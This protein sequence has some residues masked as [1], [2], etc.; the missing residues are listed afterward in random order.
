L[1]VLSLPVDPVYYEQE[2]P[3]VLALVPDTVHSVLELGCA[4]GRMATELKARQ[5]CRVAGVEYLPEAAAIAESRLDR[6]IVGDC[7]HLDFAELFESAEFDCLIAADVLEH[8]RDPELVL[9]RLMPHLTD[10]ACVVV[11]IPNVRNAGVLESAVEGNWTYQQWGILDRTHLRFFT[12]REI[13]RMFARLGFV[14]EELTSVDSPQLQEWEELDRPTSVSFGDMTLTGLDQAAIREF[15]VVQWVARARRTTLGAVASADEPVTLNGA[16]PGF[17]VAESLIS[18]L[19][20]E[21]AQ[22]RAFAEHVHAGLEAAERIIAERAREVDRL[23]SQI[24]AHARAN[25]LLRGQLAQRAE[26]EQALR[27]QLAH[28]ITEIDDLRVAHGQ[29]IATRDAAYQSLNAMRTSTSW[30]ITAPLRAAAARRLTLRG[31]VD[32]ATR[33]RPRLRAI[34]RTAARMLTRSG[35]NERLATPAL[36]DHHV[37][38]ALPTVATPARYTLVPIRN[39]AEYHGS[40]AKPERRLI[41]F[42]HIL[43]FP[44]RAGNEYR[45][46]RM[47]GWLESQGWSVLLLACPMYAELPSDEQIEQAAA[48]FAN[49]V[50]CDRD[51]TLRYRLQDNGTMLEGLRGCRPRA[52]APLLGESEDG[53]P[54]EQNLLQVLRQFCPDVLAEVLLHLDAQFEPAVILAEYIFMTRPLPLVRQGVIKA[55]DTIDVFSSKSTKVERFGIA[56]RLSLSPAAETKLLERADLVI[57]IQSAESKEFQA[58]VPQRKVITVGVDFPLSEDGEDAGP[59]P[60]GCVVVMVGSA[61]PMNAK[62]LRDFLRFAWPLVMKEIPNA[63]LHIAGSVS[64]VADPGLP[65]VRVLGRVDDLAAV[66]RAARVIINPAIAGTGLKIKTVE[67]ICQMRPL[68]LWPAGVEGLPPEACALC[69]IACDWS[70]FAWRVVAHLRADVKPRG[71]E[72]RKKLA[73]LFAAENVYATL[74]EALVSA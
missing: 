28:R 61:N 59:E 42:T 63:E 19:Q 36:L 12:R 62:G 21:V 69:D 16:V 8:L 66:Y 27:Q 43:P 67:A 35:G 48:R 50:I 31:A 44:P 18:Q 22:E 13:E 54:E 64:E 29:A 47:L 52:F 71:P 20:I 56:D 65:G 74:Q 53:S 55:L 3:E 32:H 6:V 49:L 57:G 9:R 14:I 58:L 73:D 2:R 45:V 60:S 1:T 10:N 4:N 23:A 34:A 70:D 11:S 38:A 40:L 33:G 30:R 7:E 51:G 37:A 68:V 24:A 5:E 25:Q 72:E 41:C 46:D 17:T 15:F 26:G 39:S